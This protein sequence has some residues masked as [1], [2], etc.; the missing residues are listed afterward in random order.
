MLAIRPEQLEALRNATVLEFIRRI[1]VAARRD[2]M[3]A[4]V[5]EEALEAAIEQERQ[6]A[7]VYGFVAAAHAEEYIGIALRCRFGALP[8]ARFDAIFGRSSPDAAAKLAAARA[9]LAGRA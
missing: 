3:L 5:P 4:A 9:L 7:P 8:A 2:E 6:R 1:K